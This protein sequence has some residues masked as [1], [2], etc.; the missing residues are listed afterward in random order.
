[1]GAHDFMTGGYGAS[2]EEAYKDAVDDA[3]YEFGHNAYNGT[4]STTSGFIMIPKLPD[5]SDD[6]WFGRIM[7]DDR[8][9]KWENCACRVDDE[10]PEENG[11]K[12]YIFAG[13]AAC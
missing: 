1:M 13:W 12:Y 11:R 4:I 8:I 3:L 2:P 7:D 10:I 6:D 9:C 5:E